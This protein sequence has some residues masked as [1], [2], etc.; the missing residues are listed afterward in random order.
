MRG[1]NLSVLLE[2]QLKTPIRCL[3]YGVTARVS[4]A[5]SGDFY[6][7]P[8][9]VVEITLES[10]CR[11]RWRGASLAVLPA[12]RR[13]ALTTMAGTITSRA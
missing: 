1:T 2:L 4:S 8:P 5:E 7:V 6:R 10:D 3:R 9:T 13:G 12:T 11:E